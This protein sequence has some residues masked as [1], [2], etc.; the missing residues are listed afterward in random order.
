M[1]KPRLRLRELTATELSEIKK[2]ARSRATSNRVV[3]RARII[4]LAT[5]DTAFPRLR[6]VCRSVGRGIRP[7]GAV[8]C[9]GPRGIGGRATLRPTSDVH[10]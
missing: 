1:A 9:G 8:Q 5:K 7:A 3:E 2:L 10:A 4:R 6:G